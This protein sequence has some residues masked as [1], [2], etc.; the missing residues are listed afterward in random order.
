ME[1]AVG[2]VSPEMHAKLLTTVPLGRLSQP[3]DVAAAVL[4]LASHDAQFLTGACLRV[5]G[6][7]TI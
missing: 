6:G 3:A 4:F 1:L 5:D 2:E 7:R